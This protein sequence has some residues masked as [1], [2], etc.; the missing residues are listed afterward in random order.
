MKPI[1]V[2]GAGAFGTALAITLARAGRDVTLWGRNIASWPSARDNPRLPGVELPKSIVVTGDFKVTPDD[3][4]L[5]ATPTQT[6]RDFLKTHTPDPLAL[7]ACCKGIDLTTGLGPTG[8]IAQVLDRTGAI[9]TGPSFASDIARG[10][11]TAL[12]LATKDATAPLLQETLATETMRIYLSDD[13][14]GA[15][16]GGALKNVVAIA[17]G[18][19]IG[20]GFGQSARAALM[21]RGYAEMQR[22]A[23]TLGAQPETL[24]GLSGFGDMAL[25]CTSE[26]SRNYAYG[27]ELGRNTAGDITKTIEGRATAQAVV[28]LADK[29]GIDMPIAAMVRDMSDGATTPEQALSD[30]LSRPLKKE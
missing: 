22:L 8:V 11:P 21:T 1:V 26:Q 7:V 19:C 27:L 2:A 23:M 4:L 20:A 9:L 12:T 29:H 6:L 14:V 10:L 13:P 3:I 24:A 5:L 25:T 28:A 18:I 16:L 17:C 30:L 15:E